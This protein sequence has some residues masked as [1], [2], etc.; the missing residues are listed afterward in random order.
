MTIEIIKNETIKTRFVRVID[1]DKMIGVMSKYEAIK[2]AREKNMDLV[3]ITD[4]EKEPL[5]KIL[6][7]DRYRFEKT[8]QDRAIAK[9][10]RELTVDIKEIQLR[11]VTDQNDLKTKIKKAQE[12]LDSG[13]KVRVTVK[14]KGREKSHLQ[15]GKDILNTFISGLGEH[16]LEK[17]LHDAQGNL[18]ILI[19]S[20]KNKSDLIKKT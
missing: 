1:N 14:F 16:K 8:K 4:D 19:G 12:F 3:V 2:R 17:D 20:V 18:S 5:C 9:R 6:D 13:D 10:Q 11:P 15:H 7:A